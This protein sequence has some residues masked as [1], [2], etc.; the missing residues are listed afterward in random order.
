[1]KSM[2]SKRSISSDRFNKMLTNQSLSLMVVTGQHSK[3]SLS[4]KDRDLIYIGSNLNCDVVLTDSG[5][6]PTHFLISRIGGALCLRAIDAD[7]TVNGEPVPISHSRYITVNDQIELG[8]SSVTLVTDEDDIDEDDI[9]PDAIDPGTIDKNNDH[10]KPHFTLVT[11]IAVSDTRI[12]DFSA[13][14]PKIKKQ[15]RHNLNPRS[16][17]VALSICL[18]ATGTVLG[19]TFIFPTNNVELKQALNQSTLA[20]EKEDR[21]VDGLNPEKLHPEIKTAITGHHLAT[22][23]IDANKRLAK[24]VQEILRLSGISAAAE[25]IEEGTVQITGHFG[26]G[27]SSTSV[28]ESRAIREIK[29]LDKIIQVNLDAE[30]KAEE[31]PRTD[32][33]LLHTVKG[34]DPYAI[35]KDGSRYYI[36]S[37]LPGG[38]TLTAIE[39]DELVI[40]TSTGQ[41]RVTGANALLIN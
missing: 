13:R 23:D 28:I 9:D 30:P 22:K 32:K 14:R 19:A 37:Q 11:P 17:V 20:I 16:G 2:T 29:G 8:H 38:A 21:N 5:V 26:S 15:K 34:N 24:N 27:N 1:M 33:Y 35:S 31:L 36:G 6:A 40:T 10:S 41:Q 4:L 12:E 39:N 25:L 3:A 7:L 18:I